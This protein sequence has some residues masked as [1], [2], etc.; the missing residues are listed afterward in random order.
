MGNQKYF[1][2]FVFGLIALGMMCGCA[3]TQSSLKTD[4]PLYSSDYYR[5]YSEG[6]KEMVGTLINELKLAESK[7]ARDIHR[8]VRGQIKYWEGKR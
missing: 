7:S 1:A 5:G 2:W 4:R 8:H 3:P 6:K